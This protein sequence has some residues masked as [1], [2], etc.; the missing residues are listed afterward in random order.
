MDQ[1]LLGEG[2]VDLMATCG[3]E[4]DCAMERRDGISVCHSVFSMAKQP[5]TRSCLGVHQG[6]PQKE[7]LH[8]SQEQC[9]LFHTG[10]S[11]KP[12][13]LGPSN[14]VHCSIPEEMSPFG[15]CESIMISSVSFL[16]E[17]FISYFTQG[18]LH[19]PRN[20]TH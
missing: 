3:G 1:A 9:C 8:A 10:N 7:D 16:W 11:L 20:Y 14:F 15:H 12:S 19:K 17:K 6:T 18:Q 2:M 4:S 13:I 5:G